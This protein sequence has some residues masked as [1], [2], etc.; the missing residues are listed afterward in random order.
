M[1]KSEEK[2][3]PKNKII[4]LG[5]GFDLSHDLPTSY[6][7]FIKYLIN[8]RVFKTFDHKQPL[9]NIILPDEPSLNKR[10]ENEVQAYNWNL[11]LERIIKDINE[12]I[13]QKRPPQSLEFYDL[14]FF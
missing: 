14:P 7:D 8:E 13:W 3:P 10:F 12:N 1:S 11:S 4:L 5:N 9:L 6:E 2:T